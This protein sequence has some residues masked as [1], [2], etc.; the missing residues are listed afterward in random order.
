MLAIAVNIIAATPI[1][2]W[3]VNITTLYGL[4]SLLSQI[5][6]IKDKTNRSAVIK[7]LELKII[8]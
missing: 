2:L 6:K 5:P 4:P 1:I 8:Y 7:I 3:K